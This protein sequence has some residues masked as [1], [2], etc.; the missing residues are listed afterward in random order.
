MRFVHLTAETERSRFGVE[1]RAVVEADPI[2]KLEGVGETIRADC[3][4]D[5]EAR[6]DFGSAV[7]EA[8]EALTNIDENFYRLAVVDIGRIEL[9]RIRPAGKNNGRGWRLDRS[10]AAT[11]KK[12]QHEGEAQKVSHW[13]DSS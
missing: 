2:A 3:P 5:G 12:G 4:R 13:R 7:L 8:D 6:F 10:L 1:R 11:D 9:L